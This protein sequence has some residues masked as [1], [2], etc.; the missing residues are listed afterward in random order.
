MFS[1]IPSPKVVHYVMFSVGVFAGEHVIGEKKWWLVG[2]LHLMKRIKNSSISWVW[3]SQ[4]P[5]LKQWKWLISNH[6]PRKDLLQLKQPSINGWPP[7]SRMMSSSVFPS[8]KLGY[9]PPNIWRRFTSPH[10]G[11]PVFTGQNSHHGLSFRRFWVKRKNIWNIFFLT[12]MTENFRLELEETPTCHQRLPT[13]SGRF[14][15]DWTGKNVF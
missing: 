13:K 10:P 3:P 7:G 12:Q 6:F 11:L 8:Q 4:K 2:W 9:H 15:D 1:L 14:W 5:V